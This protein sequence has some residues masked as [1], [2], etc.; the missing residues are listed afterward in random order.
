MLVS[1]TA[2]SVLILS[3]GG[4]AWGDFMPFVWWTIPFGVA[5]GA[6]LAPFFRR[7]VQAPF[8][9]RLVAAGV[10]GSAVSFG[11]I[12]IAGFV[13]GPWAM[14]FSFP[15][16]LC[17]IAAG[18]S[19]AFIALSARSPFATAV[20]SLSIAT[21]VIG[22]GY[23]VHHALDE[24]AR[25]VWGAVW[26]DVPNGSLAI[27]NKYDCSA[28]DKDHIDF[29]W[30][31]SEVRAIFDHGELVVDAGCPDAVRTDSTDIAARTL[32]IMTKPL[33]NWSDLPFPQKG[34][35]LVYVQDGDGWKRYPDNAPSSRSR[36][37]IG[38]L[39]RWLETRADGGR[40]MEAHFSSTMVCRQNGPGESCGQFLSWNNAPPPQPYVTYKYRARFKHSEVRLEE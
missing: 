16:G 27:T 17:W 30:F 39:S 33:M 2:A 6:I 14:L 28:I 13:S 5:L 35:N 32:V 7:E 22:G 26:K 21:T 19:V 38:P 31:E 37:S 12:F 23:G 40:R 8:L 9:M 15:V 29:S 11:W 1:L 36:F 4:T 20:A 10:I 34:N 18:C 24:G 25:Y 3:R